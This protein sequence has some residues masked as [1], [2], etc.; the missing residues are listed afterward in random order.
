MEK[1]LQKFFSKG[2]LLGNLLGGNIIYT[3]LVRGNKQQVDGRQSCEL[4]YEE[5]NGE[6]LSPLWSEHLP[7]LA[8]KRLYG[9]FSLIGEGDKVEPLLDKSQAIPISSMFT[10]QR[11]QKE[12]TLL[13]VLLFGA[14]KKVGNCGGCRN[15]L[16]IFAKDLLTNENIYEIFGRHRSKD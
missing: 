15:F 9:A 5:N 10:L 14:F 12:L 4:L 7:S 1:L 2:C 6:E 3:V 11:G 16:Y 13:W 8:I